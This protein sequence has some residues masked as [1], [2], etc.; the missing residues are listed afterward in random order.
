MVAYHTMVA[1]W[2]SGRQAQ[3]ERHR[4]RETEIETET[5]R[6][7]VC[8]VGENKSHG[9]GIFTIT[10]SAVTDRFG[11][12]NSSQGR[13]HKEPQEGMRS[14]EQTGEASGSFVW[15]AEGIKAA[16][17]TDG[18]PLLLCIGWC[19]AVCQQAS[20]NVS[21]WQQ[22]VPG[23]SFLFYPPHISPFCPV[24]CFAKLGFPT[25]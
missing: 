16:N 24:F 15:G 13:F 9:W 5:E 18:A 19:F 17:P 11:E 2:C 1:W 25:F 22:T 14:T 10:G 12:H 23:Q 8:V 20:S 7:C 3:R 21:Q 4:E 6:V